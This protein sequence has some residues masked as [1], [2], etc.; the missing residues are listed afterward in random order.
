MLLNPHTRRLFGKGWEAEARRMVAEFRAT[1]D[2]WSHD[3]AFASLF[4]RLH[5]ESP[6]FAKWW[7]THSI[8]PVK[9]GKKT[10]SH[11]KKGA[12][13]IA[14]ASFQLNDNPALS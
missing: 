10:L 3:E 1:Y 5:R 4:E 8:E 11:P 13:Q 12:L 6:E 2:L 9:A 7:G 14:Y